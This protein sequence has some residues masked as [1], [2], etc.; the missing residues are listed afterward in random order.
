MLT[1]ETSYISHVLLLKLKCD[2]IG[3][4]KGTSLR[5]LFVL[6]TEPSVKLNEISQPISIEQKIVHGFNQTISKT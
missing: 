6:A 3:A 4:C 2:V 5:L 1:I